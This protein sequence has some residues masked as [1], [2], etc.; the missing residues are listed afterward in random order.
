MVDEGRLDG[1]A[2]FSDKEYQK[3]I[4]KAQKPILFIEINASGKVDH[5]ICVSISEVAE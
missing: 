3:L 4:K 2:L 5:T 1:H